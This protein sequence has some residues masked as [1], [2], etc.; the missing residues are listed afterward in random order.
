[1]RRAAAGEG[2]GGRGRAHGAALVGVE[3][4]E[5]E[6]HVVHRQL[7]EAHH[8]QRLLELHA[9]HL[10]ASIGVHGK[11][12]LDRAD[13]LLLDLLEHRA[14]DL[15]GPPADVCGVGGGRLLR[16]A[17]GR[18]ALQRRARSALG[19]TRRSRSSGHSPWC[20]REPY[21]RALGLSY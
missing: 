17:H 15:G 12:D 10:A 19:L 2:V 5:G 1:M 11:E 13:L 7:G 16:G 4:V 18:F 14:Q 8:V 3:L 6:V 20:Y 9:V 21:G